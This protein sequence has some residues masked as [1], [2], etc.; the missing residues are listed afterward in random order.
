MT[1]QRLTVPAPAGSL[2]GQA[3][4]GFGWIF[5]WRMATRILGMASTL[6]L[7][8]LLAP[9]DFGLMALSSS[10]L[11][12]IDAFS[13]LGVE[14]AVVRAHAPDRR[15]YDTAFTMIALRSALMALLMA[16]G[17][18]PLAAFF[19]APRLMPVVLVTAAMTLLSG[20]E[21]VGVLEFRRDMQ[22]QRE[23]QLQVVPRLAGVAATIVA[24]LIMRDYWALVIGTAAFRL[25]RLPYSYLM[26]PY[27]PR[28]TLAG[29]RD[30]VGF[31][32][33]TWMLCMV[34]LARDQVNVFTLGRVLGTVSLGTYSVAV[35]IAGLP[36]SELLLPMG[37]SLFSAISM[38]RRSGGDAEAVWLRVVGLIALIAFPTGIGLALVAEPLVRLMLG[39]QWT[40]AVPLVRIAGAF[41][42]FAVFDHCC[43]IQLDASGLVHIDFRAVCV[44]AAV[45]VA[46]ALL[47]VPAFGLAGAMWGGAAATVLDQ[48]IYLAIKRRVLSLQPW[49]LLGQVWRPAVAVGAMA[50]AVAA[51]GLGRLPSGGDGLA[52]A[53]HLA[54]AALLGAAVY[55]GV[56]L[57]AW[58][59]AGRPE[60][61]EAAILA[62]L[63]QRWRRLRGTVL[64]KIRRA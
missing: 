47:L 28:P 29:W 50:A 26:H 39:P 6:L 44:T 12:A 36:G 53:S 19:G 64:P 7:V 60:G 2:M 31:S 22:F 56:L 38:A 32:L 42:A 54:T 49:R 43:H 17:A 61:T 14:E 21:N 55:G 15:L 13:A 46:L 20:F 51:S 62:T 5:A 34:R 8:R 35:E 57:L 40:A 52:A 27:R 48:A 41:G 24:A 3:V 59:L 10:F 25:V 58:Q 23:F 4:R 1:A 45:R 16:L 33:W 37:R 63:R 30:L 11:Q 9:A 18:A